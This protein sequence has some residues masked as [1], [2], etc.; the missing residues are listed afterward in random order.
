M[1]ARTFVFALAVALIAFSGCVS[2]EVFHTLNRDGSSL[3]VQK[4]DFSDFPAMASAYGTASPVEFCEKI[5]SDNPGLGC[6]FEGRSLWLNKTVKPEEGLYI[7]NRTLEFPYSIYRLEIRKTPIIVST[8]T[9]AGLGEDVGEVS[10]FTAPSARPTAATLG[11]AGIDVQYTIQMPGEI[12]SAENGDIIVDAQG[13]TYAKYDV[14]QLMTDGEY[15]IVESKELDLVA[16][17]IA[18]AA[19][20]LFVGGIG[21]ALVLRK[22]AEKKRRRGGLGR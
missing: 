8:N 21:V 6:A 17:G 7:F 16:I 20:G 18:V 19:V 9:S 10:D 22:A 13:K 3:V 1:K 15:M 11:L 14:L 4:M 2:V 5:M 12:I